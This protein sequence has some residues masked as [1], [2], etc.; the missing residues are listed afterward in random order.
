MGSPRDGVGS[1]LG[2]ANT[3][4]LMWFRKNRA[5]ADDPRKALDL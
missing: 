4:L 5:D 2:A 3:H 1:T